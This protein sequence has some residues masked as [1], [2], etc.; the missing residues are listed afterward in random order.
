MLS[1]RA[2]RCDLIL[3][4]GEIRTIAVEPIRPNIA[5]GRKIRKRHV[6]P[7]LIS[8][9]AHRALHC[10]PDAEILPERLDVDRLV[11]VCEGR[12]TPDHECAGNLREIGSQVGRNGVSEIVLLRIVVEVREW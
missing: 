10:P 6:D 8:G 2:S 3:Q 9:A 11:F 1:E 4:G 12:P 5:A 7:D